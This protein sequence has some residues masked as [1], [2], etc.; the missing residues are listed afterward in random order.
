MEPAIP[1]A[2]LRRFRVL[3]PLAE[4]GFGAVYEAVQVDLGR[5]VAL[6]ILKASALEEPKAVERF[7]REARGT[8]ALEHPHVVRIIDHG[9][10]D[11]VPWIAYEFLGGGTLTAQLKRGRMDWPRAL[12]I[13][14][15]ISLGLEA[16][17]QN[18]ILHRDVKPANILFA[19]GGQVKVADFGLAKWNADA[20][21]LTATGAIL[22][23]P[24]Y[25]APELLGAEASAASDQYALAVLVYEMITGQKLFT[26]DT[27]VQVLLK[28]A[29]APRTAPSALVAGLPAGLDAAIL[30]GVA[31]F[32]GNRFPDLAAFRAAL[33]A[34]SP[35]SRETSPLPATQVREALAAEA[36]PERPSRPSR[37]SRTTARASR[38]SAALPVPPAT[39]WPV[40]AGLSLV[41]GLAAFGITRVR[42]PIEE[43]SRRVEAGKL[44]ASVA[45]AVDADALER[46]R[47]A[48][49]ARADEIGL[50]GV[51]MWQALK[52]GGS[53]GTMREPMMRALAGHR[54]VARSAE[55][56][57]LPLEARG[58]KP[59]AWPH[60]VTVVAARFAGEA[61]LARMNI[62]RGVRFLPRLSEAGAGDFL[63]TS[64]SVML[65]QEF[66]RS[67]L[68][69]LHRQHDWVA[70][71]ATEASL[72]PAA[73][74]AQTAWALL[75]LVRA[76]KQFSQTPIEGYGRT[77]LIAH[78]KARFALSMHPGGAVGA[79]LARLV[80][81]LFSLGVLGNVP[82]SAALVEKI[83]E[84]AEVLARA[85][86]GA[87]EA[88]RSLPVRVRSLYPP[89]GAPGATVTANWPF[90][91]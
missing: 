27:P 42:V 8:A 28:H 72:E 83:A 48:L 40:L 33:E 4:G 91:P 17:H 74:T 30:R 9:V 80:P 87:A 85:M 15:Q 23:T 1:E 25:M 44:L 35:E 88:M 89:R 66:S 16:A 26:G 32:P 22:G 7:L 59:G 77:E 34:L 57:L 21:I 41:A 31:R 78:A 38:S 56:A 43:P 20:T 39:R 73:A 82:E 54:E 79:A 36:P 29:N 6:K 49:R 90:P 10:D 71:A 53:P 46:A 81:A 86:P 14:R 51:L 61:L 55:V 19:E 58:I 45:P 2:C 62:D 75:D 68:G 70:A 11:G 65:S 64:V 50:I 84:D 67:L 12:L 47:A 18:G 52:P 60:R 63:G 37:P 5:R 13:A 69:D 76:A 3:R 24:Y